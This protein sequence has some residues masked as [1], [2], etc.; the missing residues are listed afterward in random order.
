M[1]T[2]ETSTQQAVTDE[3]DTERS[4]PFQLTLSVSPGSPQGENGSDW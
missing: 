2:R 1:E 3:R 4:D